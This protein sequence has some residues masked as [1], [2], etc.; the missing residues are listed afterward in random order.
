MENMDFLKL[1][2]FPKKKKWRKFLLSIRFLKKYI[3]IYI[4]IF[5]DLRKRIGDLFEIYCLVVLET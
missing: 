4:Y 1:H 5:E 2:D 3:N